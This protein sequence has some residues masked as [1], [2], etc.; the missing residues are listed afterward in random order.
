MQSEPL[1]QLTHAPALHTCFVPQMLPSL[2]F[3]DSTQ[4]E[5]PVV[6]EVLPTLQ[7]VPVGV[8]STPV[9]HGTHAPPEQARLVPQLVPSASGVV[10][11]VHVAL[12]AAQLWVPAWHGLLG[13]HAVPALQALHSP[14]EQTKLVPH[15]LPF[16]ALPVSRQTACPVLHEVCPA[17]Q[18]DPAISQA[19]PPLQSVHAPRWQTL[20]VPHE[21]PSSSGVTASVHTGVP[22]AQES[23]PL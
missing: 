15:D 8:Q 2:A 6:H 12:P 18:G 5:V 4:A 21:V 19:E 11:S 23:V 16:G 22:P 7:V 17:R 13:T 10:E 3:P 20:S 14:L 9:V 1:A